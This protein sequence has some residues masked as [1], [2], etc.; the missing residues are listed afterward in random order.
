MYQVR[1]VKIAVHDLEKLDQAIAR[2]IARKINWLAENAE[3]IQP[4][5]LR[6]NLAGLAKIREGDYRIIYEMIHPEETLV[7]HFVGHRREVC[8]NK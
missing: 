2:R 6:S 4:K 8:K 1:F 7:I 5:N 3:T